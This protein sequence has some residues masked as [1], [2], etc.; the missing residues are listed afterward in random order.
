MKTKSST[1]LK[2]GGPTHHLLEQNASGT[3]ATLLQVT[4]LLSGLTWLGAHKVLEPK[5]LRIC[6]LL[7]VCCVLCV[8]LLP[9]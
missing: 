5:W 9:P 2:Q 8:A 3:G 6:L 1:E 4:L 7:V